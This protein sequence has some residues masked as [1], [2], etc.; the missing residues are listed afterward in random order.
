MITAGIDSGEVEKSLR[1]KA[2][3][4]QAGHSYGI[5]ETQ[6]ITKIKEYKNKY[7]DV[8][9]EEHIP[10]DKEGDPPKKGKE[11]HLVKLRNP[12]GKFEWKGR[13]SDQKGHDELWAHAKQTNPNLIEPEKADDGTFWMDFDDVKK[14]FS[15]ISIN[16]YKLDNVFSSEEA[17]HR[18]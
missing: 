16:K 14:Y 18:V 17:Q 11:I 15:E 6:V 2:L 9:Y 3:G 10:G 7:G 1:L 8:V 13:W 4:L 5:L 12:W